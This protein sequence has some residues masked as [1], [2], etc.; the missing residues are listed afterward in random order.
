MKVRVDLDKHESVEDAEELLTKAM[1]AK[2]ECSGDER[3]HDDWL[4]QFEAHVL[5]EHKKLMDQIS[6]EI[7]AE[8]QDAHR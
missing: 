4:N 7:L 5:S 8:I 2:K 6:H 3:Y 1:T